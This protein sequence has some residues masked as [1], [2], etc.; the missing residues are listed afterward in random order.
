L[1]G[2]DNTQLPAPRA[3]ATIRRKLFDPL[4][5]PLVALPLWC[6]APTN[7][8]LSFYAEVAFDAVRDS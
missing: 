5:E 6:N 8:E 7:P 4:I 2:R 3:R 1:R